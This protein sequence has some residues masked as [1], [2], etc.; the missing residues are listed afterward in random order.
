MLPS[1]TVPNSLHAAITVRSLVNHA[2][3]LIREAADHE[4]QIVT[5]R[6]LIHTARIALELAE[7]LMAYVPNMPTEFPDEFDAELLVWLKNLG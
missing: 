2:R 3:D 4:Q 7:E 5:R 1:I 6:K